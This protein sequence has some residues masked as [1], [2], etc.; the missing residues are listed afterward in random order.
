MLTTLPGD[1]S[2]QL[3]D[4]VIE[5]I[6]Y[7]PSAPTRN[8]IVRV[9][10]RRVLERTGGIVQ[11]MSGSPIIQDGAFVAALTHVFVNDPAM[12]YGIFAENMLRFVNEQQI[13]TTEAA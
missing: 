7:D 6:N 2:P 1:S 9:T 8:L 4:V 12:G 13:S 11:G 3:Y 10:D 5:Q